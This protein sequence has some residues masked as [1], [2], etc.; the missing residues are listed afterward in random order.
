MLEKNGV[1]NM[2]NFKM[3]QASSEKL[4]GAFLFQKSRCS[5]VIFPRHEGTKSQHCGKTS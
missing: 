2:A 5:M 1:G 4:V 3:T